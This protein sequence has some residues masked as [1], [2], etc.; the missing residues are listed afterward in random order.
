MG[1][2]KTVHVILLGVVDLSIIR[3]TGVAVKASIGPLQI[4]SKGGLTK[5]PKRGKI[6]KSGLG[7]LYRLE[8]VGLRFCGLKWLSLKAHFYS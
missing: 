1:I 4:I 3:Q 6:L 8:L 5:V 2:M 7:G